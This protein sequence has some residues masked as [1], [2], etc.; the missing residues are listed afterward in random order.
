M[1]R[2]RQKEREKE[3]SPFL[4]AADPADGVFTVLGHTWVHLGFVGVP[5]I[6]KFFLPWR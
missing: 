4:T 5:F 6:D 1:Q 2:E 3:R